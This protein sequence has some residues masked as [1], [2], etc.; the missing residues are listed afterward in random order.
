MLADTFLIAKAL[1]EPRIFSCRSADYA[2]RE[3][4]ELRC[5]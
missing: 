1:H 2:A 4:C 3:D 5:D